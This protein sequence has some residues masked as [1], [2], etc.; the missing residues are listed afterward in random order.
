MITLDIKTD[1][2][3][4]EDNWKQDVEILWSVKINYPD[5]QM[6]VED[7]HIIFKTKGLYSE[8]V[9]S[10]DEIKW[11]KGDK[12]DKG[13][14]WYTPKKWIDYRDWNDGKDWKDAIGT[15]GK[16]WQ[17]AFEIAKDKWF[18]GTEEEW[19]QSLKGKDWRNG[20]YGGWQG[21]PLWWSTNQILSKR[22]ASDYDTQWI[23]N[24][25]GGW[26]WIVETIVAWTN[27]T[28]DAT[29]P[30]NPIV[31][32]T[33][34]GWWWTVDSI[35]AWN[36]IDV[37]VTDPANPIVSV[38]NLV[39]ADITD[40]T[41]TITEL[42][43]IDWVTSAIQ[44]QLNNKAWW[45]GTANGTNTGDQTNIVWITGTKAQ[46]DTACTDGN[47]LY[48]WDV[49]QYTDE[50]AQDAVWAMVDSSLT[51]VDATPLLQ[52]AA[53]TGAVTASA[54]SNTTSLGSFTK[55]QLNTAVSDWD[56]MY[57]DSVDTV[58]GVKTMTGLNSVLHS[59]SWLL[60]RN[61][62]NTFTYT[63][64]GAAIAAN[65]QLNLPL[66][67]GTD[68]LASL[69]LSQT[70]T[71]A[72]TFNNANVLAWAATMSV[73][74]TT[75]TNLSFGW[76]A[77]TLNIWGT[78]TGAITHNYSTNA[79]LT[80]T[81]K[82]VNLGTGW[83]SGSTT[84]MNIGSAT[85]GATNNI[86]INITPASDAA[87]DLYYRNSS[88]FLSRIANGTTGQV[89]TATTGA[90]PSW[91]TAP[92]WAPKEIRIRVPWQ[93]I[94][95]T[96]NFQWL[97]WRNTT[98]ATITVTNVAVWVGTAA[99]WAWAACSVNVYKSSGTAADWLNTNAVNLFTSAIALTTSYTSDTNAPNTATVEAGRWVTLRIT[100][101]A[102]A[103]N[104][105]S[106]L[107]AVITYT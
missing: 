78:P 46:F 91:A 45:T 55:A 3:E 83:A 31:S 36:N 59:S 96:S 37:D 43:Y 22:S 74:N 29:D 49:T 11:K 99:A 73:F 9:V 28:V 12:W 19:L 20:W 30:A 57:L 89:L 100:A 71:G 92:A 69:W 90:A 104:F 44:T 95:D 62:A 23:D 68:T 61:P 64:T 65:R 76:A 54:W 77:T 42:N 79:T 7:N 93:L 80:G 84:A 88:G 63:I 2:I 82:T 21:V 103:T 4:L 18:K 6:W 56:V 35:V 13:D 97:Y 81:T 33:W 50:M 25:W 101:S 27:I 39:L 17:S 58:T 24:S 40:V 94:A 67:T 53:L 106:D 52:R 102:G 5:I 105:A 16:D 87:N 32:A 86:K 75:A 85:S 47:F 70:F 51:Y 48:A 8:K 15:P 34:W 1:N 107:E 38:E 14:D 41:A 98:G 66:I 72:N 26:T 60:V 10:L